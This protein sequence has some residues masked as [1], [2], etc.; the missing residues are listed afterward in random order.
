MPEK[1]PMDAKAN[2]EK[3]T[4]RPAP[5]QT[6]KQK[7]DDAPSA[8]VTPNVDEPIKKKKKSVQTHSTAVRV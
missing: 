5:K 6:T 2:E 1:K 3:N 8:P 7:K 4:S